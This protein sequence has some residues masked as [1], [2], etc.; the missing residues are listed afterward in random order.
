VSPEYPDVL[1]YD[2]ENH[3][4]T[5]TNRLGPDEYGATAIIASNVQ[6]DYGRHFVLMAREALAAKAL[7][8]RHHDIVLAHRL[9]GTEAQARNWGEECLACALTPAAPTLEGD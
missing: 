4:I 2:E 7:I 1:E 3:W 5:A 9:C 6:P 8:H